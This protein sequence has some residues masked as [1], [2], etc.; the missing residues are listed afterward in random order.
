MVVWGAGSAADV[1]GGELAGNFLDEVGEGVV[2]EV[3]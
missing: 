3:T 1:S 2:G